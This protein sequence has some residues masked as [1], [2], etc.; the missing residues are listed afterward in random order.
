MVRLTPGRD[1]RLI[2]VA[3]LVSQLGDW[4]ARLAL[5]LLVLERTGS[6]A[7]VGFVGVLF[8][9]PWLGIGQL[10]TAWSS[11]YGRRV[12]L[13]SC[14]T[15][16][17]LAFLVI[18]TI[19]MGIVPLLAIVGVAALA[20]PVF[21]ATKSAFVTEIVPK[22]SYAEA[23]QVTHAATQAAA[24]V[25]YA[26]GGVMVGFLGA[27]FTLSLNG[28]T[29]VA[30]TLLFGFVSRT[31][32]PEADKDSRPSL[33][34]GAAFLRSD[35]IVAV[36]FLATLLTVATAMSVESQVAVY[37]K[38]VA[39]LEDQ[40]LGFLSA[41]TPAA[42]LLALLALKTKGDDV[43]TLRRGLVIASA[44]AAAAGVLLFLGVGGPLAFAAFA[45]VG[46]VFSFVAITNI[47]VGR[48]LP[49]ANRVSIFSILQSAIYGGFSL[50][51]LL[52]GLVSD[53]TTP[54]IAAG[55]ALALASAGL[56]LAIP[57]VR[58]RPRHAELRTKRS[59]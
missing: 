44:A 8:V 22:D 7:V 25:G 10:L 49:D 31:G 48:R 35:P 28:L 50:G 33:K 26:A 47:V 58:E 53:A 6:A 39:G 17:A 57:Y 2:W 16:R 13:M 54:E 36:S 18:G 24:L 40:A 55:G 38:V 4:S 46:V 19:D 23:I 32:R 34:A 43:A 45:L 29:F 51:A 11:Q 3:G 37:G 52:G 15:V 42:S 9:L 59:K 21:E 41:M 5:A 30:S 1:F 20:D 56:L 12:V 14:D 27:E